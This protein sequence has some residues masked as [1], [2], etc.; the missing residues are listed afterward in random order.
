MRYNVAVVTPFY[1]TEEY[2][3][4]C[5]RSVL[6]Q[7]DINLQ[8]FLIDDGSQDRS[9]FIAEYY[10]QLDSRIIFLQQ[11]NIYWLKSIQSGLKD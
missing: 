8:F 6:G 1:N 2:L 7:K 9:A 3:H 5:I 4:R 11:E 10:A